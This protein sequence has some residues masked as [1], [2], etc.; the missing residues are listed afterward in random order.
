MGKMNLKNMGLY[1]NA[2]EVSEA[3]DYSMAIQDLQYSG[4]ISLDNLQ[5]LSCADRHI[6]CEEIKFWCVY[7]NT[8]LKRLNLSPRFDK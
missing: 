6:L 7:G 3:Y 5:K 8:D 2:S 4:Y 1:S